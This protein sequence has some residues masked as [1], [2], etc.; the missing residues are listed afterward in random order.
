MKK[1]LVFLLCFLLTGCG[2][3]P[4]NSDGGSPSGSGAQ[5][6]SAA[7]DVSRSSLSDQSSQ[8]D[9]SQSGEGD[10]SQD[11]SSQEE[12]EN[13][14]GQSQAPQNKD[15]IIQELLSAMS[16]P[17]KVGQMFFARCPETDQAAAVSQYKLGGYLLFG[18]DF[19]DKTAQQVRDTIASYQTAAGIPLLIGTDEEGGTVVRASANPN[20]FPSREPSPQ[21]L[22]AQGGMDAILQDTR[23]KSVTLLDLGVNVNF[24]PVADVST[25]PADFIYSR[26]LGEDAQTTADYVSQVVSV[27]DQEHIGSVLKHFPGYGSNVDTHT[28][29]AIDQ[30]PYETF[31]TSDFLPFSAGIQAGADAVLVSHNVMTCVDDQLPASL[32]PAVHQI[33]RDQLGFEGVI[34]T[35]D[36]AMD[37]VAQYAQDGSAAV[38]AVQAGNDMVV[39]TDFSTQIPQVIAAVEDGTIPEDQIDQS[40]AR[41]L[42]WKYDLGLLGD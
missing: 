17:E 20:L 25:D 26:S 4:S 21:T 32:S 30:R 41:V 8:E 3:S 12:E 40:V 34:L 35:D 31:E 29:V 38:L 9:S 18:R 24:A 15:Q 2:A 23:Q 13:S 36:L 7:S 28:G 19:K 5:S 14:D 33:L 22:Y 39:T 11:S 6:G 1:L 16:L 42:S 10:V 37:A 27:M